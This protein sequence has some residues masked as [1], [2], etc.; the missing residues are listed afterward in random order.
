MEASSLLWGSA[1]SCAGPISASEELCE[2]AVNIRVVGCLAFG[3]G[4]SAAFVSASGS[5]LAG[6]SFC[7]N[8][9][10]LFPQVDRRSRWQKL[11]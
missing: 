10:L 9:P 2:A 11:A 3:G 1:Q 6:V 7:Q 8:G 5:L 4:E